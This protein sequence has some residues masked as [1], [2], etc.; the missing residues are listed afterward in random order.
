MF[1]QVHHLPDGGMVVAVTDRE[2]GKKFYAGGANTNEEEM[3]RRFERWR[4]AGCPGGDL[5]QEV[6]ALAANMKIED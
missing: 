3:Q 2:T 5:E 6:A 4:E 1:D